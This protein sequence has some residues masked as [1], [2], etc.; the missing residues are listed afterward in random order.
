MNNYFHTAEEIPYKTEIGNEKFAFKDIDITT[1]EFL[2]ELGFFVVI[3]EGSITFTGARESTA[4][5][6]LKELD[7][8][9]ELDEYHDL[10]DYL[11]FMHNNYGESKLTQDMLEA[12]VEIR[13]LQPYKTSYLDL[14][15][16]IIDSWYLSESQKK[17]LKSDDADH[18]RE[19]EERSYQ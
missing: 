6:M 8:I 19:M 9:A 11:R 4:K 1:I 14:F 2:H 10:N 12:I 18:Y 17:Q 3:H 13:T 7:S 5:W 16:H 15:E